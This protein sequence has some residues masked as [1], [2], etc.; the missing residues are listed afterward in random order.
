M[1]QLIECPECKSVELADTKYLVHECTKCG[2]VI[3]HSEWEP[4]K[5]LIDLKIVMK[6]INY[7]KIRN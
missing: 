7:A 6:Y 5:A 3:M 4:V 2:Y 1:K